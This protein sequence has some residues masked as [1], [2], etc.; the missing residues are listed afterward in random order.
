[1]I[2]KRTIIICK[3]TPINRMNIKLKSSQR[4]EK[5]LA[6]ESSNLQLK[7]LSVKEPS[8]HWRIKRKVFSA[9]SKIRKSHSMT[10]RLKS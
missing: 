8:S 5:I 10:P 4:R 7:F 6:K 3:T 2:L 1:M 9:I